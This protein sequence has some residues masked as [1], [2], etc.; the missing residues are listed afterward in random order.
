[1][2]LVQQPAFEWSDILFEKLKAESTF[3]RGVETADGH[4]ANFSFNEDDM[5]VFQTLVWRLESGVLLKKLMLLGNGIE[6][7]E[8]SQVQCTFRAELPVVFKRLCG[9]KPKEAGNKLSNRMDLLFSDMASI[10]A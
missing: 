5:I 9:A 3:F 8:L 2:L 4:N 7:L 6:L 1:M 10:A